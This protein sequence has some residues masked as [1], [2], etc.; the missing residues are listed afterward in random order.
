LRIYDDLP[1]RLLKATRLPE[2]SPSVHPLDVGG[3]TD[4]IQ[5]ALASAGLDPKSGPLK[6]VTDTIERALSAAGLK[7]CSGAPNQDGV[8]FDGV[9]RGIGTRHDDDGADGA[10]GAPIGPTAPAEY[11][12]PGEFVSRSFTNNAGTRTYKLYVPASYSGESGESVPMV[13]MLHGCTQSPDDFAAGTRMNVLAE[14]HGFL[15]VYPAQAANANGSK[16]WNWFRSEDQSRDRGEPLL[17]A[18]ITRE[19]ASNYQ[20]DERRIF[21]AGLSAGAAM[22]VI[23]G[24]TYPE[25]Y[26]AVGAHSG[27]AYGAAHDVPSAFGVMKG[28]GPLASMPNL[29]GAQV[30]R[31]PQAA[32]AVPTIVFHGDHDQTVDA[33]NG[34]AIVEQATAG[35]QGE[36]RLRVSVQE[37]SASGGR[38][39]SRTVYA[40]A[41]NQPVVEHWVL[42]GASHAWSGGNPSGS[43]TDACG[44]DASAEMIRF[45]YSQPRARNA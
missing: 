11:A 35:R 16:C 3:I 42:H 8:T 24:A 27:L 29:P 43:F 7:Q 28:A 33:R 23:L 9:A 12:H 15:V 14:Q 21:V 22:A 17:I 31:R 39:Y 32:Q 40:D 18:G 1:I 41:A 34:A 45:F 20:V 36:S 19:V 30:A 5:R 25:L 26:A 44:P 13:V 4:T 10:D 6:G 37:R 2:V 38:T